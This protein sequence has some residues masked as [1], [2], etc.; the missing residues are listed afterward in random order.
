MNVAFVTLFA[1]NVH[2]N[3]KLNY[4]FLRM[5]KYYENYTAYL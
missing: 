2:N 3:I 4:L 1:L 5:K